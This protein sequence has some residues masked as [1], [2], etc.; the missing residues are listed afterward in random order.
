MAV[1][2]TLQLVSNVLTEVPA[3]ESSAGSGDEGKLVALGAAG[4]IDPTML[5]TGIGAD[6][7]VINATETLAAGAMV[8]IYNASGKKCR[9]ADPT[10]A[11]AGKRAHGFVLAG[12]TSGQPASVYTRGSNTA[13]TGLTPGVMY[14]LDAATPG[15]VVALSAGPTTAGQILQIVGVGADTGVLDVEIQ[16]PV[17]RG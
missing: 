4:T 13:V 12:V 1:Q 2:K 6:I 7:Q 9:N 16:T 11:A 15:G 8:N 17:I 14:V 10:A 5:P 3:T